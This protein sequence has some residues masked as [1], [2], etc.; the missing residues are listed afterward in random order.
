MKRNYRIGQIVP[1]SN[2]T[3]ET[4]I[5]AML[6]ARQR[7]RPDHGT[8]TYHSSRMRMKKVVKEELEAMDQDSLRCAAELAD[9]QVDVVGYACLVAIMSMG[10]GYHC[11][12]QSKLGEV[13]KKE[14][15]AV[16]VITSAG[17]LVDE[18]KLAGVRSVSLV[19]PYL[20]PLTDLVVDYIRN[21]GIEV[22]DSIALCIAD[23]LAVGR[24]DPENLLA[25]VA[26]LNTKGA[27]AVVVSA[28]VQM[29]SLLVIP[30]VEDRLGMPVTSAAV[31]TTRSMLRA[32]Q[33][34]PVAPDAGYFLSG[35]NLQPGSLAGKT[36]LTA[37]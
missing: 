36:L 12:S 16:P 17:A 32:L 3:M 9:A 34:E 35:A 28:C 31:C 10:C 27:D 11:E 30:R 37:P 22:I 33:L 23:N 14:G 19:T 8:F 7:M 5:P 1:S 6:M 18:L 26:R 25:D 24:R 29:P 2:T 21:E 13:M 15:H 4:E 20:Q